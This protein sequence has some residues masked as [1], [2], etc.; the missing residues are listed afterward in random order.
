M[1]HYRASDITVSAANLP[2]ECHHFGGDLEWASTFEKITHGRKLYGANSVSFADSVKSWTKSTAA[3]M[4]C[5]RF[6]NEQ[7]IESEY[8]GSVKAIASEHVF[9]IS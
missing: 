4:W 5:E 8:A 7:G 2:A 9:E 3:P 1:L 6:L